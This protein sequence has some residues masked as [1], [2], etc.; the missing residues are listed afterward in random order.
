MDGKAATASLSRGGFPRGLLGPLESDVAEKMAVAGGDVAMVVDRDGVIRDLALSSDQ[1]AR[2]GAQSWLDRPWLDTVTIESRPKVDALLRDAAKGAH[3]RWRE[4]NQITAA[5]SSLMVRFIALAAGGDGKVIAIGRDERAS[6]ALQQRLVEAQQALERDFSKLREAE[7][8]YRLLFR[9]SGEAVLVIDAQARRIVEA[10]PAA[11]RLLGEARSDLIGEGFVGLFDRDS[12]NEA[13]TLIGVAQSTARSHPARTPLSRRGRPLVASASLFRQDRS[14]YCL[15]RLTR[16][17]EAAVAPQEDGLDLRAV[18]ERIPDAFLVADAAMTI[19]TANTAF[20]DMVSLG[21]P[22]QAAGRPLAEFL[23]RAGLERNILL[24]ALREHGSVRNFRTILRSDYGEAEDVEVSAASA[25]HGDDTVFGFTI[26]NIDRRLND[27]PHAAPELRRSVEQL[28][29]LVGRMTLK[30]IVRETTDLIERLCI[31]AA[32]ELTK[33]NRA[34]A[35]EV[36]G[37]S[38]QSLYSKLRRFGLGNLA[39]DDT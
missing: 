20:L 4:I 2:E 10:N 12:H 5:N 25:P 6:A 26:R 11:E 22:A 21:T 33:N 13:A 15:V 14:S 35:A 1:L 27:R 3:P 18:V 37:L 38:R 31:E 8:R 36:L 9:Q 29:E 39:D 19:L 17:D 7:G 34:S 24:D 30:E 32:L 16:P 28:T 23:G